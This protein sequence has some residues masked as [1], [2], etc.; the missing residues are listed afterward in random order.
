MFML[1]LRSHFYPAFELLVVLIV[2]GSFSTSGYF[3]ATFSVYLLVIGLLYTP[4]IFNPNGLDFTY[5]SNDLSDWID[6]M[7]SPVDDPEKGWL[8]WFSKELE[9]QRTDLPTSKK[10]AAIFR[11]CRY[12]HGG[13]YIV[14]HRS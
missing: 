4:L 9:S 12:D 5:A 2:Y 3:L 11:R 13:S 7:N 1:Y 8:S 6:W 14:A 10:V